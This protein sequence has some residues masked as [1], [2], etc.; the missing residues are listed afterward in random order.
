MFNV[1]HNFIKAFLF[2]RLLGTEME[3]GAVSTQF[4]YAREK[5]ITHAD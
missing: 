5:I 2:V 4:H 3:Y 1:S